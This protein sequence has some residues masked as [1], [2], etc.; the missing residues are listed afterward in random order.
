MTKEDK[1]Y[2]LRTKPWDEEFHRSRIMFC[3]KDGEVKVGPKGTKNSH[4]EWFISEGWTTEENAEEFMSK[5][6]R[7][8]YLPKENALYCYRG[9]GFWFDEGVIS[10]IKK[11]L[12]E[13]KETLNLNDETK[14]NFGPKDN[15]IDGVTYPQKYEGTIGEL[16]KKN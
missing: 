1:L 16:L 3:I 11:K 10:E 8:F 6:I 4:L 5:V 9:I 12:P 15:P 13:I 7:G 2:I 14:I